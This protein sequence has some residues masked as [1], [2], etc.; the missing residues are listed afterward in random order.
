MATDVKYMQKNN[1]ADPEK[2]LSNKTVSF[3][4]R[5]YLN[6]KEIDT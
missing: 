2:L 6:M 4:E 5:M 3:F 1:M